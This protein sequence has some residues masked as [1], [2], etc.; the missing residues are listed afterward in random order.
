MTEINSG[1]KAITRFDRNT[2]AS[3]VIF[4]PR[5][6]IYMSII[7]SLKFLLENETL[8]SFI[9]NPQ[10]INKKYFANYTDDLHC[11]SHDLFS[12][13]NQSLKILIYYDDFHIENALK[14]K[15]E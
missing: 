12:K 15:K 5:T 3:K 14:S 8:R 2:D 4:M 10:S 9:I 6:F 11:T 1:T 7:D 13:D